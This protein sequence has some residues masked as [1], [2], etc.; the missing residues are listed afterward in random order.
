[1]V[2]KQNMINFDQ[3]SHNISTLMSHCEVDAVELSRETGLPTSTISRLRS[4]MADSSPNL[5]SLIPIAR[6]FEISVSQLIGEEPLPADSCGHFQ[7][8]DTHQ[9]IPVLN[10]ETVSAYL[11]KQPVEELKYRCIDVPAS[12]QAFAYIHPG[13]AMEPLFPANTCLVLD[14]ERVAQQADF[15]LVWLKGER[16]P[17][18]RQYLVDGDHVYLHA[19][20]PIFNHTIEM[21]ASDCLSIAVLLQAKMDY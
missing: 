12:Q 3:L 14:P 6:Y 19:L 8:S 20:N 11:A 16:L 7:P 2:K 21:K 15:V 17:L 4:A 5:S 1:M 9:Y 18:F 10:Q 13:S